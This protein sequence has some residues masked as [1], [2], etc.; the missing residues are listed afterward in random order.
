MRSSRL[1][2]ALLALA[3]C[4]GSSGGT[5]TG[6]PPKPPLPSSPTDVIVNNNS[7]APASLTVPNGS[8]VTWTWNTCSGGDYY[9][10][11]GTC[12]SH[13]IVWDAPGAQGSGLQSDGT[14]TRQFTAPG[15]Y[16]YHCAVHGA[17]M[18]G[19]VVVQ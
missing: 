7:F 5:P 9:G 3:A 8:T 11:G 13:N 18:S 1:V 19:T 16:P 2:V 14:F 12:V 10:N 4:G 15:T 6:P 17:A